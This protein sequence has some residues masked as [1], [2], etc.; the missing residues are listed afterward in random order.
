MKKPGRDV[1]ATQAATT[2]ERFSAKK[3]SECITP[4]IK[5]VC[6]Y[7]LLKWGTQGN[8]EWVQADCIVD[9]DDYGPSK[10]TLVKWILEGPGRGRTAKDLNFVY[11]ALHP[12]IKTPLGTGIFDRWKVERLKCLEKK[13]VEG[14]GG[15]RCEA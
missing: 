5:G 4:K 15:L 12:N 3:L 6:T 1:L 2:S 9:L 10:R 11:R 14:R 13:W 8:I 7:A